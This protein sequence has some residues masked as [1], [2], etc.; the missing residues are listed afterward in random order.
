MKNNKL[1][2]LLAAFAFII[3]LFGSIDQVNGQ[4]LLCKWSNKYQW[5]FASANDGYCAYG[6]DSCQSTVPVVQ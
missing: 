2:S 5:C 1:K 3:V 4:Q 6:G